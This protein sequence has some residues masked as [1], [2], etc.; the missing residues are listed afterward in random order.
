[1]TPSCGP[2]R[3]AGCQW[4]RRW[5]P[6][7]TEKAASCRK[8]GWGPPPLVGCTCLTVLAPSRPLPGHGSPPA[9]SRGKWGGGPRLTPC[10]RAGQ[11]A[12]L[13]AM[14]MRWGGV[15]WGG[16]GPLSVPGLHECTQRC[17]GLSEAPPA[18]VGQRVAQPRAL[19]LCR[20]PAGPAGNERAE[21]QA[22][23]HR[24]KTN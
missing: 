5:L 19:Q 23:N 8:L 21:S 20:I 1:V 11:R 7:A 22:L 18:G 16:V 4:P 6:R 9:P 15:G 3:H 24:Q 14:V 13:N 2:G 10:G 17:A 12:R